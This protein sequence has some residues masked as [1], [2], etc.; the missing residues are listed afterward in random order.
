MVS[1]CQGKLMRSNQKLTQMLFLAII[2]E[3]DSIETSREM[4]GRPQDV[5]FHYTCE[6][7]LPKPYDGSK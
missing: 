4:Y 3:E 5:F 7:S 1:P 6:D 2:D